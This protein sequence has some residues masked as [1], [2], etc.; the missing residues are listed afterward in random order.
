MALDSS[1]NMSQY[2]HNI[3]QVEDGLPQ[4]SIWAITQTKDGYIWLGTEEGLVRFDGI[5][6]TV[7]DTQN[8]A[9]IKSHQIWNFFEDKKGNFWIASAN[10]L[11]LY[12]NGKFTAYTTKDGLSS[13]YLRTICEDR[14][15]NIWIGTSRGLNLY[16]NGKFT[17]YTTKDGLS[18]DLVY[19]IKEDQKG[20]L[21][22]GTDGGGLNLFK[23]GKFTAYTTKNGL[24]NDHVFAIYEDKEGNLWIGTWGGGLNLY[25]NGKFIAY[26]SKDGLSHDYVL[27]IYKDKEKNFW[28]GTYSGGI[29]Q[30][31]DGKFT[32]YTTKDGLSNNN[33][34]V[35]NEDQKGNLWVG[36]DGG[37]LNLFKDGKFTVYNSKNGLSNDIVVALNEDHKGNLWIGTWGGGL[38]LF[39]DGKFITYNTKDGLSNNIVLAILED[40]KENLWIGTYGGGLNL[41]KDGKFTAFNSKNGLSSDFVNTLSKDKEGN[42]WVG[43]W[44][45]G[46]NLFKD[47]KFT[48]FNSKNGLSHNQ[49]RAISVDK[50]GNLWVGT[51]GG[52][53]NLYINGKFQAFTTKE[54]LFDDVIFEILEDNNGNLWMSSHKGIFRVSKHELLEIAQG[55][56]KEINSVSYGVSDGMKSRECNGCSQPAGWKTKE[57]KMYFPTIKGMVMINPD[58]IKLNNM[59]P[60]VHIE[61]VKVDRK[62]VDISKNIQFD[63]G[64]DKL[65]FHYTGLSYSAPKKVLFKYMIK[66]LDKDWVDAGTRRTAYYNNLPPGDYTFK[67]KACNNDGV[68][69]ETGASF[70]FKKLP[71][72]Y[73]TFWFYI[74]C[75]VFIIL[76]FILI[77]KIR[78]KQIRKR[79]I[80]LEIL[81][82]KLIE[83]ERERTLFFHNTSHELRTPLNGIIGFSRL[84][85]MGHFGEIPKEV[86]KQSGKITQLA[87][88]LKLQVN[89]ILDLAKSKKNNLYIVSNRIDMHEIVTECQLL[90]Q[91]LSVNKPNLLFEIETSWEDK[92]KVYFINDQ[93]KIMTVLRNLLG[94]AFKFT[95][96]GQRN[97]VKLKM[98]LKNDDSSEFIDNNNDTNENNF[99]TL[100][101]T[102]SDTGI[103]IP[104]NQ[105]EAIFEEFKQSESETRRMYEGTGLG[106]AMVKKIV[107]LMK[108]KIDLDSKVGEGTSF[109]LTIPTQKEIIVLEKIYDESEKELEPLLLKKSRE[110]VTETDSVQTISEQTLFNSENSK[111]KILVVDDN[112]LNVEVVS[113]LLKSS[114]YTV[115]NAYGGRDA[116]DMIYHEKP[117]LLLLDL[118]MPEVSGEDVLKEIKNNEQYKNIPVILLTARASREDLLFGFSIG[119]DDYLA[120]PIISEELLLRVQSILQRLKLT[121]ELIQAQEIM[122]YNQKM[123]IVGEQ[124]GDL[125]HEL[126]NIFS[127][128]LTGFDLNKNRYQK[129]LSIFDN[130]HNKWNNIIESTFIV[131]K[132]P[133]KI[134]EMRKKKLVISNEHSESKA[135]VLNNIAQFF[136]ELEIEDILLY[137]IWDSIIEIDE[138]ELILLDLLL[139]VTHTFS[140]ESRAIN[141]GYELM[142]SM[143]D[144][145]R[146]ESEK[147]CDFSKVIQSSMI[148]MEKKFLK[149]SIKKEINIPDK[150]LVNF[151]PS[152]FNQ[153]LSNLLIN[154]FDALDATTIEDKAIKL[155]YNKENNSRGTFC[156]EDNGKGIK[157]ENIQNIFKR[158]FSTKGSKGTGIGLFI[159]QQLANKNN[160]CLKV[161]SKPGCTRFELNVEINKDE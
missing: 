13:N 84:I 94:N 21:W 19:V 110:I 134:R 18:F 159:S 154:A 73:Q 25:K 121:R 118:M 66:G 129:L 27:S 98:K 158:N 55:T 108:G 141:N 161:F 99:D 12:K 53:L 83:Q 20:N 143:L 35:I 136:I 117:D 10:G 45:N 130:I 56:K 152:H 62:T 60:P 153:I 104:L 115:Q 147:V 11:L 50:E 33:V 145:V 155:F 75:T 71:Y 2:I 135:R 37:G 69:N 93:E 89:T 58:N 30:F 36:T 105:Q 40:Q 76:T 77:Y 150:L 123:V 59:L 57:G 34:Y 16:K 8:T 107:E 24:S 148:L 119:A 151:N 157:E 81:N 86:S 127:S 32:T 87:E 9:E 122:I 97:L 67:V 72:F 96:I 64:T 74:I 160:S 140:I 91:G 131:S 43:T 29:N 156:L 49:V 103:G 137:E 114:G 142:L 4:N 132:I 6:F 63:P 149:A 109:T 14:K 7:F 138:D 128:P 133:F 38:N 106:L 95:R 61:S 5:S 48:A 51:H 124:I 22:I 79:Q 120:K 44:G 78:V 80:Q 46:L 3:W 101:V 26:T 65:E 1:K 54:G 68:W 52:G 112:E 146:V 15:G 47:G 39:K 41:F 85:K 100:I 90:A 113:E 70:S 126:K 82:S 92:R 42:L 23:D 144:N 102:V 139:L 88:S 116:L 17:V 111:F 125:T 31:K 28:V